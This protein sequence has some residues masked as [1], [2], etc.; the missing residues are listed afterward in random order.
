[1]ERAG[2]NLEDDESQSETGQRTSP[3]VENRTEPT[4]E[5]EKLSIFREFINTLDSDDLD[6]GRGD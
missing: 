3:S 2:V 1:M 5:D 6:R 4:P